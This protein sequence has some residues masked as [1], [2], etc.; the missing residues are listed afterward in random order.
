VHYEL[1][2]VETGNIVSDFDTEIEAL[3][4]VRD[5]LAA[6]KPDYAGALALGRT[7]DYG[8]TRIVAEGEALPALAEAGGTSSSRRAG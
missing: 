3:T 2:D 1:W 8:R 6:N 4:L 5:L 7:D